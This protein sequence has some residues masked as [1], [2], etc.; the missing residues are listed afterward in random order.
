MLQIR[1]RD[2][3]KHP[4]NDDLKFQ[5]L[6][7]PDAVEQQDNMQGIEQQQQPP[8]RHMVRYFFVV[9]LIQ[10]E[11]NFKVDCLPNSDSLG[12][13]STLI[14]TLRNVHDGGFVL[15]VFIVLEKYDVSG[16]DKKDQTAHACS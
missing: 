7:A 9:L 1:K 3:V 13:F 2:G 15:V 10:N 14:Q 5:G 11:I 12:D 6:Q 4:N 16:L 8:V